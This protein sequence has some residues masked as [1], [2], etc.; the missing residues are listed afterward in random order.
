MRAENIQIHTEQDFIRFSASGTA[1]F[2]FFAHGRKSL[3]MLHVYSVNQDLL[4]CVTKAPEPARLFP[5]KAL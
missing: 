4:D 2:N 3:E 5:T 1:G